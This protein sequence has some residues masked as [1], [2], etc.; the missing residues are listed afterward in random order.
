MNNE[1]PGSRREDRKKKKSSSPIIIS[2]VLLA[3]GALS[4]LL[5]T[6]TDLLKNFSGPTAAP[7]M[8][9]TP[10]PASPASPVPP[11][12]PPS[13][14][15]APGAPGAPG[16]IDLQEPKSEPELA[17][18]QPPIK[19][20]SCDQLNEKLHAFFTHLDEQE[21]LKELGLKEKSEPYFLNLQQKL[22]STPPIVTR[23]TD[24]LLSILK[25]MAHIFRTIGR[26]NI[27]IIKAILDREQEDIEDM[28]QAFYRI[29]VRDECRD[30]EQNTLKEGY[31]DYAGFFL[32]TIGGRAYLFRRDSKLR[33]LVNYYSVLIVDEANAGQMNK[34][35]IDL[36][37]IIPALIGEIEGTTRLIYKERYLD[38]L[39]T[40]LEQYQR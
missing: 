15:D 14:Q 6:K 22:L 33:L 40:I 4:V 2:L 31:Y 35:G 20:E 28:A 3:V 18:K 10:E 7:P 5:F 23:E 17:G 9:T 16:Q 38:R 1:N 32:T 36:R 21:Y 39:Y 27:I 13:S 24:N 25:N 11:S 37:R 30:D 8:A 34:Y 19:E 29:Y 26:R 12:T